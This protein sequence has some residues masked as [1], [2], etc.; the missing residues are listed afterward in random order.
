MPIKNGQQIQLDRNPAIKYT[1]TTEPTSGIAAIGVTA[2]HGKNVY[3]ISLESSSAVIENYKPIF[4]QILST[5][6][7]NE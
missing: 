4:N 1:V 7:F 5:F 3:R 2:V 6:K